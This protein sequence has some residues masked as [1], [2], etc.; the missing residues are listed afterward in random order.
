MPLEIRGAVPL[1]PKPGLWQRLRADFLTG[2]AVVLPAGL[3]AALVV[4]A[5]NRIDGRVAP[6]LPGWLGIEHIAGAGVVVFALVAMLAGAMTRG[7]IGRRVLV[8]VERLVARVPVARS[9]YALAKQSLTA[10][11]E[12]GGASFRQ[13]CLVEYPQPGMWTLGFIA[14]PGGAELAA[15]TGADDLVAVFVPTTPNPTTGFLVFSRRADLRLLDLSFEYGLK[16]I[17][18]GGLVQEDAAPAADPAADPAASRRWRAVKAG[19][20]GPG[21]GARRGRISPPASDPAG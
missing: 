2:L 19:T 8:L 10:V 14:G 3:T 20:R 13:V 9:V 6:L 21:A 17:M 16:R 15:R 5:V 1:L 11:I 4:W 12:R 7:M 18:S